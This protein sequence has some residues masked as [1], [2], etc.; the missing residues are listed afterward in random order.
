M[1]AIASQISSLTIDYSLVYSDADQ[2]K[3]QNSASLAFV[4]G[5]HR[6][7]VNS[8]HKWPITRKIFPFDDVIMIEDVKDSTGAQHHLWP[9]SRVDISV[10]NM[11]KC[12]QE[13]EIDLQMIT[14]LCTV[15]WVR[16]I[17]NMLSRKIV[18]LFYRC[19]CLIIGYQGGKDIIHYVNI[20]LAAT[21]QLYKWYF[22]SVRL[23]VRLS[24]LFDYVPIIVSSWNCQELLPM[25]K[26]RSMQKIKV[27]GQRSRSQR[28]QPNLT[29]SGL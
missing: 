11:L 15:L 1:G 24:H 5:I 28:S 17:S 21:K 25:T 4:R 14:S 22:P 19:G 26:V 12:T 27:R 8:P 9:Q 3:H 13:K 23:S 10:W 2:R 7:P 20:F 16:K 29:V 6:G 18:I